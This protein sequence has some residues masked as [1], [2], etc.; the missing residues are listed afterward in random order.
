MGRA[1]SGRHKGQVFDSRWL[2]ISAQKRWDI[3][4]LGA[5][6]IRLV[7]LEEEDTVPKVAK[8]EQVIKKR[9]SR[10]SSKH[11]G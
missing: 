7:T 10:Y 4:D 2:T 8:S 5:D 3:L 11:L 6:A 9:Q 1:P